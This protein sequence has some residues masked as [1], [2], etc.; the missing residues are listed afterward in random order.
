[1]S[2]Y[3]VRAPRLH[4]PAAFPNG[5]AREMNM[6]YRFLAAGAAICA[7][8]S[9]GFSGQADASKRLTLKAPSLTILAADEENPEVDNLLDPEA[10]NGVPGG[11]T[12]AMPGDEA[13]AGEEMRAMP[14]D[15]MKAMPSGGG[16]ENKEID[17]EEGK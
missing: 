3:F 15:E 6:L 7:L 9:L 8:L 4:S 2:P 16:G 12:A 11:P 14:Q 1:M 5:A 10:T 17:Q 13:K